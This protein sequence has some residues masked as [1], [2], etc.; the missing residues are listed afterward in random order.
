MF[1]WIAAILLGALAP[2]L[3]VA[4]LSANLMVLPLVFAVTLAHSII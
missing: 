4:G 2:A 3:I 1:A